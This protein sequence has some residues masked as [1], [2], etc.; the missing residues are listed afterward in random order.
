MDETAVDAYLRRIGA[1]RPA[2]P[3]SAALRTLHRRHLVAVPFENLSIHRG[4]DIVLDEKALRAK[5][6]EGRRGGFCYELNGSFASLL[7]ALG[8]QVGLLGARVYSGERLSIPHSHM[9]LRVEAEDG[10]RW[11]ADVGFGKHSTYPL[12]LDEPGDQ[13]DPGGEFRIEEAD[14]GDLVVLMDGNRE[15][16]LERRARALADFEGACWYNR[17]SPDSHFTR[18]LICSRLAEDGGRITLSGRQLVTT[19]ADGARSERHLAEGEVLDVYRTR[20]GLE[21]DR[22]PQVKGA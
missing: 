6:V 16:R 13:Q 4:E 7:R 21:L 11:L 15:Y 18:S 5:I 17:T 3:D 8:Y 10:S 20:F 2:A 22:E 14:E 9:T 19:D 1:D 12:T